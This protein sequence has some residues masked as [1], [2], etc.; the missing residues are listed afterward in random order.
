[1]GRPKEAI[2]TQSGMENERVRERERVTALTYIQFDNSFFFHF[3]C[4]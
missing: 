2:Y 4:R 3:L 1:M